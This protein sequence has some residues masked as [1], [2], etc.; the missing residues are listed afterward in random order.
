MLFQGNIFIFVANDRLQKFE[1][2]PKYRDFADGI[3]LIL[4]PIRL[5]L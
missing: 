2:H 3:G 1:C 4:P 5:S